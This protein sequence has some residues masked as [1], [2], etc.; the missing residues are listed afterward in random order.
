[1]RYRPTRSR[2]WADYRRN[3]RI[4][5]E[6]GYEEAERLGLLDS[7]KQ[8]KNKQKKKQQEIKQQNKKEKYEKKQ[9]TKKEPKQTIGQLY[10]EK[11]QQFLDEGGDIKECPFD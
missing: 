3:K 1:M 2:K 5:Q 10:E 9:K 4:I 6:Y 8:K 7:E 11:R